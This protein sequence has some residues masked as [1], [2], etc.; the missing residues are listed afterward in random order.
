[1][2]SNVNVNSEELTRLYDLLDEYGRTI[3][4][5]TNRPLNVLIFEAFHR[6]EVQKIVR[7]HDV[8][9]P[10]GFNFSTEEVCWVWLESG[11]WVNSLD[12]DGKPREEFGLTH[13]YDNKDN[14]VAQPEQRPIPDYIES[15]DEAF[16]LKQM[17]S[18]AKL[19]LAELE[20]DFFTLWRAKL[21]TGDGDLYEDEAATPSVAVLKAMLKQL[22]K[23]TDQL[24][25]LKFGPP[26]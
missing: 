3:A 2:Q 8:Q 10:C 23:N 13:D 9:W 19:Q 22:L 11:R 18:F 24:N 7:N 26:R 17:L 15:L 5:P 12:D 6:W 20:G 16:R 14:F 21:L 4:E 25:W 1:M